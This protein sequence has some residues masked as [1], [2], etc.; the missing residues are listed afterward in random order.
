MTVAA[1]LN[2]ESQSLQLTGVNDT[3]VVAPPSRR[4]RAP[5]RQ[6]S[7]S[8]LEGRTR[9]RSRSKSRSRSTNN[10][11]ENNSKSPVKPKTAVR[12]RKVLRLRVKSKGRG[13]LSQDAALRLL[14]EELQKKKAPHRRKS[15]SDSMP[16][17][18]WTSRFV[19]AMENRMH[20][21]GG[22]AAGRSSSGNVPSAA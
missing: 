5:R 18:E 15:L 19:E 9:A 22:G 8:N 12:D 20:K 10:T 17:D 4:S 11:D 13:E 6:N 3:A 1:P 14:Q 21:G 16:M 2:N 7:A